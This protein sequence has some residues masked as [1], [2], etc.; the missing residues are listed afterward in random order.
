M[1]FNMFQLCGH[2]NINSGQGNHNNSQ[3]YRKTQNGYCGALNFKFLLT[4]ASV[5]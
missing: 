1:D 5:L 3:S 2:T 4:C